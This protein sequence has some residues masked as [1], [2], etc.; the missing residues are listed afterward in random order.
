M[1]GPLTRGRWEVRPSDPR[2]FAGSTT[3]CPGRGEGPLNRYKLLI[4]PAARNVPADVVERVWEYAGAGGRVL[5]V[6]ESL[7]GDE[8][9]HA[10][11]YLARLGVE[12][13][14]IH[15]PQPG[16][17]GAMLQGYD[18]SFT[19][20]VT[21][22][23]TA[24][25]LKPSGAVWA[26]S[27]GELEGRGVRQILK[28]DGK[29][30]TLFHFA[31]GSPALFRVPVGKGTV[32]YAGSS[33]EGRSYTRLLDALFEDAGVTRTLRVR[34]LKGTDKWKIEA[35][36]A[37]L[38]TRRLLYIANFNRISAR[39]RLEVPRGPSPLLHDLREG[40]EITGGEITLPARQTAIYEMF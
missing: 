40:R 6:P 8:Y 4:V 37:R 13:R 3:I 35:R 34:A 31:D 17:V 22:A 18:Q 1:L 30:E 38:G 20:G 39:L 15:R 9:N 2:G 11:K 16:S 5:A 28:A 26:R 21:F 32:Y 25:R 14:E 12:V 33:F 10:R 36:F 7:L 19:Q 27:I 23:D 29:A 24:F